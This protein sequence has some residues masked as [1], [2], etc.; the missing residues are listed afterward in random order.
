MGLANYKLEVD[1]DGDDTFGHAEADIT[2]D[3]ISVQ[4]RS[5]RDRASQLTGRA[6][7]G[8]LTAI[9]RNEDGKYSPF[10]AASPIFGDAIPARK[11]RLRMEIPN[12]SDPTYLW[13]GFLDVIDPEPQLGGAHIA[14]LKARGPLSQLEEP[15]INIDPR[16]S[17][18]PGPAMGVV[19]DRAGWP[20]AD[21][22]IDEGNT[23]MDRWVVEAGEEGEEALRAA[24]D[25]AEA[26]GRGFLRETRDGKIKFEDRR[27]RLKDD[28]LVIQATFSDIPGDPDGNAGYFHALP[29]N[30]WAEVYNEVVA[31]V[32]R[33][34]VG[35]VEP[36]WTLD[37]DAGDGVQIEI[38]DTITFEAFY[39][40]PDA[41]AGAQGANSWIT[42][43]LGTDI[44]ANSEQDGSGDNL[45]NDM[46]V[47]DVEKGLTT[48]RFS[49]TNNS[50]RVAYLTLVQARGA[51]LSR[52]QPVNIVAIVQDSIDKYG[53]RTY[54]VPS[55][56]I[57]RVEDAKNYTEWVASNFSEPIPVVEIAFYAHRNINHMIQAQNRD[58]SDRIRIKSDQKTKLGIDAAYFIE[59]MTHH[60]RDDGNVHIVGLEIS[61]IESFGRGWVL[62]VSELDVTTQPVY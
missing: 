6:T 62:D 54:P 39:P 23:V 25:V 43:S 48:M 40:G 22:D 9:L 29:E 5:G 53:R 34:S 44:V 51:N 33:Q 56:F 35:A 12:L 36:L 42:P 49:V 41:A 2:A 20:A 24:Y 58:V 30:A 38:G 15:R 28:H 27:H 8:Q 1:W 60:I 47:S 46:A 52:N 16:T 45:T 13:S 37:L 18:K 32:E 50:G 57:S 26:E 21:R 19:F 3:M 14:T 61:P 11:V 4:T 55:K 10:Q 59:A 7:A 17:I 31:K